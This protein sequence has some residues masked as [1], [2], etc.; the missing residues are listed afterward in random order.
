[1]HPSSQTL[2][3]T[4]PPAESNRDDQRG[5]PRSR[6]ADEADTLRIQEAEFY[7]AVM[8]L[9]NEMPAGSSVADVLATAEGERARTKWVLNYGREAPL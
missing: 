9:F 2:A 6:T 1:M 5:T 7:Q 4:G 8:L 3:R